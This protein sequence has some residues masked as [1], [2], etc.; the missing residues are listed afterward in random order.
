MRKR[1]IYLAILVALISCDTE[2][3]MEPIKEYALFEKPIEK[4]DV[5]IQKLKL[6]AEQGDTIYLANDTKIIVPANAFVGKNGKAIRGA[7]EI[8]FQEYHSDAE[9]ILSGIPM[10]YDSAGTSYSLE[11]DGMFKISGKQKGERIEIAPKKLLTV[12]TKSYK[13]DTPCFNH[14]T[15]NKEGEWKYKKTKERVLNSENEISKEL[16]KI[17]KLD[18]E[19]VSIDFYLNTSKY[20]EL[21]QFKNISWMY[22]GDKPDTLKLKLMSKIRWNDF[23]LKKTDNSMYSYLLIGTHKKHSFE[24]PITPA[25]SGDELELVNDLITAK[26]KKNEDAYAKLKTQYEREVAISRFG[27][28]NW[29]RCVKDERIMVSTSLVHEED[30]DYFYV[31]NYNRNYRIVN[32]Y[33]LNESYR[34]PFLK[35]GNA[36]IIAFLKTEGEVAYWSGSINEEI[37][38]IG[39]TTYGTKITKPSDLQK[40]VDRM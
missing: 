28:H 3:K 32:R 36:G 11:T 23:E 10:K 18:K 1:I 31:I 5:P 16:T 24:M 29:D 20:P 9:V 4:V 2:K 27:T 37:V 21:S 39:L 30:I 6:I 40:L 7:V 8:D 38:S 13:E 17:K 15:Q 26:I 33:Y 34:I 35:K 22:N 12:F 14:Y 19:A 25:F